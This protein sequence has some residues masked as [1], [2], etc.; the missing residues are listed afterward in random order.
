MYLLSYDQNETM[1]YNKYPFH[2]YEI[3]SMKSPESE[4]YVWKRGDSEPHVWNCGW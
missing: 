4:Q 3:K 1:N 2:N